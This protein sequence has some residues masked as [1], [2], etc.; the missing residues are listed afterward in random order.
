MDSFAPVILCTLCGDTGLQI[1]ER[2]DGSRAARDCACRIERRISRRL[3]QANIPARFNACTLESFR[4]DHEAEEEHYLSIARFKARKFVETFAPGSTETG[5]LFTGSIGV[6]KTHLAVAILKA[7]IEQRGVNGVFYEYQELLKKIQNSY[8]KHVQATELEV[9]APVF[10][11]EV[12]VIDELGATKP[13]EWVWDTVS[14]ILNKRY[15]DRKLTIITTNLPNLPPVGLNIATSLSSD[16]RLAAARET[17]GD[18][19]GERMRSRL[20]EMCVVVDMQGADFRQ[21]VNR[22]RLG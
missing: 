2:S 6:G 19:I 10:K 9:L 20:Q 8:N 11:A 22:A 16:A 15:N 5:I 21:T 7:L 13:T 4:T 18:R 1:V 3:A 12:L 14:H 17:L